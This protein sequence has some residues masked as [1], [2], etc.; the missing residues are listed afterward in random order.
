MFLDDKRSDSSSKRA[1]D[2]ERH[3]FSVI[4]GSSNSNSFFQKLDKLEQPYRKSDTRLKMNDNGQS[5][6]IDGFSESFYTSSDGIHSKLKAARTF[7][8]HD[9]T[10][11]DYLFRPGT[12]YAPWLRYY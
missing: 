3:F 2:F 4:D 10:Q 6:L 5:R 8:C 7:I 12:T 9:E 11:N 1:Y